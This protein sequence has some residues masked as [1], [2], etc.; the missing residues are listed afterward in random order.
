MRPIKRVAQRIIHTQPRSFLHVKVDGRQS[1]FEWLNSGT[2]RAGQERGTMAIT[3]DSLIRQVLFGFD[4]DRLV[5]RL[6]TA[7]PARDDLAG[8][9][10]IR[11]RF[12]EPEN[13]EVRIANPSTPT[14]QVKV[15]RDG[16]RASR[17]K[18]AAATQEIFECGIP[19]SELA[20]TPGSPCHFSIELFAQKQSREKIPS[21]G[22]FELTVPAPD[23]EQ[24]YWQA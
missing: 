12:L 9:D 11:L 7:H 6:D 22:T 8:V 19:L 1:F 24:R 10:E 17:S 4:R 13:V 20:I 23:F 15:Q 14:P 21:E 16:Q 3:T 18:A 5:F 2:Y